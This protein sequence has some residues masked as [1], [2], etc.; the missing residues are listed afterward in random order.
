LTVSDEILPY[1]GCI[2]MDD[3]CVVNLVCRGYN[4]ATAV[5]IMAALG[6]AVADAMAELAGG[7]EGGGDTTTGVEGGGIEGRIILVVVVK[8]DGNGSRVE[9]NK[10]NNGHQWRRTATRL[11]LLG[12]MTAKVLPPGGG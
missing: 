12:E 9:G 8:V 1:N 3:R 2:C 11:L 10:V 7:G 6:R 5:A 4:L